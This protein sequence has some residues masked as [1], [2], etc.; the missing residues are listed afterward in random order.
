MKNKFYRI[1]NDLLE[2]VGTQGTKCFK[3]V[4]VTARGILIEDYAD[5]GVEITRLVEFSRIKK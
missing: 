5:N 2:V 1:K 4:R 3:I